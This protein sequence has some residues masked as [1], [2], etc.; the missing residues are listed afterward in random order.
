MAQHFS[1]EGPGAQSV[2]PSQMAW[3]N[4]ELRAWR[5]AGVIEDSHERA[6]LSRYVV[7]QRF[8][9]APLLLRLGGAFI[10]VGLIWLVASNLDKMSPLL[11]FMVVTS[12][13]LGFVATAELLAERRVHR[14]SGG[15]DGAGPVVGAF[16]LLAALGFGAVVFQA[17]QSLQVPAF[18]PTLL[19]IWGL[20]A[21]VYAY[22][23]EGVTALLV[24]IA[25]S[26]GWYVWEVFEA[27]LDGMGFVLPVLL[28]AVVASAVAVAHAG[29]WRPA[30]AASWRETSAV[31][32]LLGLFVAAFPEVEVHRFAWSIW[33][34]TGLVAALAAVAASVVRSTGRGR[35][36]A[37][38]PCLGVV[39]GVLLVLWE[40]PG[41]VQGVVPLEGYAHAFISVAVY[42]VAAGWY[43]V[44][45]VL[46]NSTRLTFL[47][48]AALVLFTTVQSFAVFAPIITGATLFLIL[49]VILLGSGYLFDRG[50]RRL[51]ANLEGAAA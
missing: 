16:R 8:S 35:L 18:E 41:P 27:A 44:L 5:A 11:R 6:I 32:A 40:A 28:A 29:R 14:T 31:M 36:E 46:R 4:G 26:T 34:V 43:A 10:G 12:L 25:V 50:R 19:G 24:G 38:A 42:V 2:T 7:V 45:G 23:V 17:A 37:V 39:A 1:S 49:G 30:F 9:L 48:T 33:M 13:W 15:H 3:L 22:A 20:G 51:V 21:L 47:G